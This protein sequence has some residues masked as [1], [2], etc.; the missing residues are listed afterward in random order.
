MK[1]SFI[2]T[3]SF[4]ALGFLDLVP[5]HPTNSMILNDP[6]QEQTMEELLFSRIKYED[7]NEWL[8]DLH[9]YLQA[10]LLV[11]RIQL[12]ES[13]LMKGGNAMDQ[14][15]NNYDNELTVQKRH[16][17]GLP[18]HAQP[19]TYFSPFSVPRR[20][21]H[22]RPKYNRNR[23]NYGHDDVDVPKTDI[24]SMGSPYTSSN[25]WS[26]TKFLSGGI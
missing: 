2:T 11:Q 26:D 24:Y 9:K 25:D 16:M 1:S 13:E 12:L 15:E 23:V 10:R 5:A 19:V 20:Y 18:P 4:I 3:I 17:N 22:V 21:R 8:A 6:N 14:F 7:E